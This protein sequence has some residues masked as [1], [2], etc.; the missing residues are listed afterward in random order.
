MAKSKTK[1][2]ALVLAELAHEL[3]QPLTGIRASAELLR[4]AH[5]DDPAVQARVETIVRQAERIQLLL[6]RARRQGPPPPGARGDLNQAVESAWSLLEAEATRR[7][8]ALE[9]RLAPVPAVSADQVALEQ[10]FGN[11]LR[12][13]LEAVAGKG[14]R[15]HVTTAP[16]A[17]GAEAI[18]EDDGPGVPAE[19]RARLFSRLATGRA[20]GTGLG[21]YISVALAEEAGGALELME[22]GGGARFRLR[23]P[24]AP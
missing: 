8:A 1:D 22:G 7:G 18:V 20:G 3:R 14:G 4:E 9:L 15:I 23:L 13:A 17:G 19:L 12:N 24:A 10:I 21:L 5:P 2:A 16:A 11:L 6:E